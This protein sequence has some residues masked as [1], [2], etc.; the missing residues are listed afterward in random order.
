[1]KTLENIG[2]LPVSWGVGGLILGV[3]IF[4]INHVSIYQGVGGVAEKFSGQ[5][6]SLSPQKQVEKLGCQ[7]F[8]TEN[9]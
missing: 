2:F 5:S 7:T 9:L 6:R 1:M 4:F 3:F 8:P